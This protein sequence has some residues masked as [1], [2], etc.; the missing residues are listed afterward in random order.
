MLS[1]ADLLKVKTV[2]V[3][4]GHDETKIKKALEDY[5]PDL[6]VFDLEDSVPADKKDEA[7]KL[8]REYASPLD[9][10]RVNR[11]AELAADLAAISDSNCRTLM[12]PKCEGYGDVE[13]LNAAAR[14]YSYSTIALIETPLGVL[15]AY[16]CT[17][18]PTVVALAF[19]QADFIA[20]TG[21]ANDAIQLIRDARGR[22]S[23]SAHAAGIAA[24]D[25]P[26]VMKSRDQAHWEAEESRVF[27]YTG[28]GCIF[29]SHLDIVERYMKPATEE[30]EF[31]KRGIE[32]GIEG[33]GFLEREQIAFGPPMVKWCKKILERADA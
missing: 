26:C 13:N 32:A 10:V 30:V 28:K 18:M 24:L 29:P 3:V 27:G 9:A 16:D 1:R 15:R 2:L 11:G 8:V 4:P 21:C 5:T 17:L 14:P 33:V 19:G 22:V 12:L 23:L 7:R 31:A 6:I 20:A 25:S